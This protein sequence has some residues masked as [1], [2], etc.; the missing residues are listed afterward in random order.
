M[1]KV[2]VF[3]SHSEEAPTGV[4]FV[5]LMQPM[6]HLAKE[7]DFKVTMWEKG[8]FKDEEDWRKITGENDIIYFN[9]VSDPWAFAVMGVLARKYGT[10]MVMDLDDC[11]W[12]IKKDNPASEAYKKGQEGIQ[13]ISSICG[14]VDW[15]TT[16]NHYL[17]NVIMENTEKNWDKIKIFPNYIDLGVY[18][19]RC[20]FKDTDDIQIV[21]FGSTTHFSD[22]L[23]NEFVRG[24]D[25][26]MK[27]YPNV[28]FRTIGSFLP[29]FKEKWGQRY[30]N[31]FGHVDVLK[32]IK[33]RYK[34]YMSEA[35]IFVAPLVED[36]YTRSKSDIKRSEVS[37]A[38]IPFIGQRIRQYQECVTDGVDGF[39]CDT[40]RSWYRAIKKLIDDK[41]LR[42]KIG[43][44]G[45]ER[46]KRDKQIQDH[47]F[48][49]CDFFR[50]VVQ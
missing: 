23:R 41:K 11:L 47:I 16:T 44:A 7:K 31:V 35:D 20:E 43:E 50:K 13:T 27:E 15:V 18:N 37:A 6:N 19:H 38:K 45:F 12:Q 33:Y 49:Y 5:R 17:R 3:P 24:I 22:L 1:I 8:K 48:E 14:E 2:F 42:R 29:Q 32:W 39:L 4:D 30:S 9:Y 10:K 28:T 26:I 34:Q 46:V 25:K 36:I 40:S 21:H